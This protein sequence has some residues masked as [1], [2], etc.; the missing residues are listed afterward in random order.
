MS[1]FA[2]TIHSESFSG[3]NLKETTAEASGLE[4]V[5]GDSM[6]QEIIDLGVFRNTVACQP[7]VRLV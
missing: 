2:R 3:K 7:S 5:V 6:V 4:N 1:P